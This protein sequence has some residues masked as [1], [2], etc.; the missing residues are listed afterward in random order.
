MPAV[1]FKYGATAKAFHWIIV[2]LIAVQLPLGWLM[3]DIR[4]GMSP[5]SAMSLHI[6]AGITILVLIVLRFLWRL[7]H[8]VALHSC[9]KGSWAT[10]GSGS[11]RRL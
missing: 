1:Q 4:R 9:R 6:S 5:G 7:T 2:A 11:G 8:P 3:P 10:A